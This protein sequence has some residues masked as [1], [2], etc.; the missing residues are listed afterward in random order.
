MAVRARAYAT[1]DGPICVLAPDGQ[2][3]F[4]APCAAV[5]AFIGIGTGFL[6]GMFGIGGGFLIVPALTLAVGYI[7]V[8]RDLLPD[9]LPLLGSLD[10]LVVAALAVDLFLDTVPAELLAEKLAELDIPREA[11]DRV[12][13]HASVRAH[14]GEDLMLGQGVT[15]AGMSVQMVTGLEHL[16]TRMY[17]GLGDIIRGWGK[18]VW[19]G[20]RDTLPV[21]PWGIRLLRILFPLPPLWE[22]V[23]PVALAS[24]RS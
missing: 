10:D 16:F 14:V 1:G 24:S 12:G 7:L 5:L 19:A 18:N 13:G 20:G 17:A 23:A 3:R 11:Y 4:S 6:S 2:L 15:R 9:D 21:G 22:I 8:G